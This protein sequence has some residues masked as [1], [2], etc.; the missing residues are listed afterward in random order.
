MT[1]PV[2]QQGGALRDRVDGILDCARRLRRGASVPQR[3]WLH[4]NSPCDTHSSV[5]NAIQLLPG[6][7]NVILLDA[8]DNRRE[9]ALPSHQSAAVSGSHVTTLTRPD[10]AI[11]FSAISKIRR[12]RT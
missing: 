11:R 10:G 7:W 12:S 2:N 1:N 8:N 4:A 6:A 9:C 5:T 3:E